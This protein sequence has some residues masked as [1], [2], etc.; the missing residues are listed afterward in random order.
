MMSRWILPAL[1]ITVFFSFSFG[2]SMF[3]RFF[4][5]ETLRI[6]YVHS[7]DAQDEK[8]SLDH[9]YRYPQWAGPINPLLDPFEQG[10]YRIDILDAASGQT[11]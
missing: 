5:K 11:I 6:D 7:G 9:L 2:D 4:L 3:D 10:R 8:I 1:L